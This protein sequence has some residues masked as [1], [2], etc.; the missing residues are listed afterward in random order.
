[1]DPGFTGAIG[2]MKLRQGLTAWRSE[3][4][5]LRPARG[6]AGTGIACRTWELEGK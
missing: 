3:S 6:K 4:G 2:G 5:Q 1:M